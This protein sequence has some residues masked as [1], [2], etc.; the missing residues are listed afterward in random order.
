M[1][2][3]K[4][5]LKVSDTRVNQVWIP[6]LFLLIY[7]AFLMIL[8]IVKQKLYMKKSFQLSAVLLLRSLLWSQ[9]TE[10]HLLL[11]FSSGAGNRR[12]EGISYTFLGHICHRD[13]G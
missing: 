3:F 4:K 13:W 5:H 10:N 2:A 7:L 12:N 8:D 11:S 9:F 1:L 6:N